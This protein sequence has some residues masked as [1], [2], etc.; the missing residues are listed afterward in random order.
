MQWG[1]PILRTCFSLEETE[2]NA[3]GNGYE[4]TVGAI[5]RRLL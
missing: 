4:A 3:N 1:K 2:E 5:I